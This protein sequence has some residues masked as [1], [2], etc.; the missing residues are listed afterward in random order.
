MYTDDRHPRVLAGE[1][2]GQVGRVARVDEDGRS[3]PEVLQP[4]GGPCLRR[5]RLDSVLEKD[6]VHHVDAGA[7]AV[8]RLALAAP[9]VQSERAV[10]L[11][12]RECDGDDGGGGDDADPHRAVERFHE[13]EYRRLARALRH[14]QR[15]ARVE[16]WHSEVDRLAARLRDAERGD[17]HVGRARLQVGHQSVP[18]P[19][20][21]VAVAAVG[22]QVE[23]AL[24]AQVVREPLQQRDGQA[25][26]A[27]HHVRPA[28]VVPAARIVGEDGV[29]PP[30]VGREHLE[31]RHP[32]RAR[33][34]HR[35]LVGDVRRD[36][37]R[38]DTH[39]ERR[40]RRL[41][42]AIVTARRH[43]D[44]P[45][46][47]AVFTRHQLQQT[48]RPPHPIPVGRE[49]QRTAAGAHHRRV[50]QVPATDNVSVDQFHKPH[51]SYT[52]NKTW[53]KTRKKTSTTAVRRPAVVLIGGNL[54]NEDNYCV[55]R[56]EHHFYS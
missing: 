22:D 28:G 41:H 36:A 38:D 20:C 32:R 55:L 15:E 6:R 48:R 1:E 7:E 45:P 5:L 12:Q 53:K 21:P 31:A 27:V 11:E 25:V 54:S 17:R 39:R 51:N 44:P 49:A 33:I 4:L 47:D 2:G 23:L 40:R 30:P 37:G 24:E 19:V 50:L 26:A 10:P 13:G 16:V 56:S 29:K 9:R 43:D 46:A 42:A 14:D 3:R 52:K 35:H 34:A 18:R 8:V